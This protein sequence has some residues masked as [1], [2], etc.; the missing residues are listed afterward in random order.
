M[1]IIE[2]IFDAATG[3]EETIVR[4]AT[5]EEIAAYKKAE[6]ELAEWQKIS[7]QRATAKQAV[8]DKLGLTAEE[9]SAL[10]G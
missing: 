5:K 6:T 7:E 9:V 10:I 3:I 1:E 4:K 8:L 2:K